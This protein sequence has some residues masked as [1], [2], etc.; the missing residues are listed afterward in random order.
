MSRTDHF[1]HRASDGI[2]VDLFWNRGLL[3]DEFRVEVV[4]EREGT[5]FVLRPTTGKEA[6][7]AF[8]HPYTAAA[9]AAF[10][11][12]TRRRDRAGRHVKGGP[13]S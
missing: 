8:Y 6:I 1:G 10:N 13:N 12:G 2:V 5:R 4:D 7:D 11:E 9:R 3:E